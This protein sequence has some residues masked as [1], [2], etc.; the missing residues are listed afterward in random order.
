M[1]GHSP[2]LALS[3]QKLAWFQNISHMILCWIS[4]KAH[5]H[6]FSIFENTQTHTWYVRIMSWQFLRIC[7]VSSLAWVSLAVVSRSLT[8]V[9][10]GK[11]KPVKGYSFSH[12][13]TSILWTM[14]YIFK[15]LYT[16]HRTV[17][18]CK[19]VNVFS[20]CSCRLKTY[21]FIKTKLYF[22]NCK[23]I[24]QKNTT[25][26]MSLYIPPRANLVFLFR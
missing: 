3:G 26:L 20:K 10:C 19:T 17:A 16:R 25:A 8:L 15:T 4:N 14:S 21:T 7:S 1:K 11:K 24:N 12:S 23:Y 22:Q 5:Q 6:R 18:F 9:S 13:R 2:L